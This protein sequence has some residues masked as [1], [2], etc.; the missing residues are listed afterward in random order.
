MGRKAVEARLDWV[1]DRHTG[2]ADGY[3]DYKHIRC[4]VS[5][6]LV[7]LVS[8]EVGKVLRAGRADFEG[9]YALTIHN[10]KFENGEWRL[11]MRVAYRLDSA[12]D[13]EAIMQIVSGT[14]RKQGE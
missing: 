8:L 1:A 3:A 6:D 2:F 10:F 4:D 14:P 7:S 13:A 12:Q 11:R 9:L 5:Q